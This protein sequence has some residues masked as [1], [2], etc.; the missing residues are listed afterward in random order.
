VG[1]F[2][3][4]TPT[5]PLTEAFAQELDN[6]TAIDTTKQLSEGAESSSVCRP[7]QTGVGN[8]EQSAISDIKITMASGSPPSTTNN[9]TTTNTTIGAER[10]PSTLVII[11]YIKEACIALQIGDSE[12][13]LFFLDLA[14]RELGG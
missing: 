6:H 9:T 1:C 8:T 10:Y 12:G 2:N 4:N 7:V 13:A 5:T 11:D 3:C 14:L